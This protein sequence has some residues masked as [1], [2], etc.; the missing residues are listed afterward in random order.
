ML[1]VG[2]APVLIPTILNLGY[3]I[4][5]VVFYLAILLNSVKSGFALVFLGYVA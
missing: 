3:G 2:A 1:G 4:A 5:A